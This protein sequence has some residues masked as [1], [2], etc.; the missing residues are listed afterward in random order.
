MRVATSPRSWSPR[1][2][3]W[4]SSL[5]LASSCAA[6]LG[7]LGFEALEA[8]GDGLEGHLDLAA[9]EAE[10]FELLSGDLGLGQEALGFAVEA[11]ER[12][13]RLGL[14]VAGLAVRCMSC[15]VER[16]FCS[17]CCSA[18]ATARTASWACAC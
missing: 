18:A 11:G 9:L 5:R 7:D 10:G 1:R 16:R 4:V 13:C 17:A 12:G 6:K 15:M 14:F 8:L 2:L 3:D